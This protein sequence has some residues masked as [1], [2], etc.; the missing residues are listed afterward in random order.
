MSLHDFMYGPEEVL[1][2]S[3]S[4][5]EAEEGE[6]VD[7]YISY[8]TSLVRAVYT[9]HWKG[10]HILAGIVQ[11]TPTKLHAI[12]VLAHSA[13]VGHEWWLSQDFVRRDCTH[14]VRRW[15]PTTCTACTGDTC[16]CD[17]VRVYPSTSS[18][19]VYA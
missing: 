12:H 2:D 3:E 15:T 1:T 19:G 17:Y 6:I 18:S 13:A 14:L 10:K 4:E 9:F 11:E 16:D 7:D 8:N 5:S